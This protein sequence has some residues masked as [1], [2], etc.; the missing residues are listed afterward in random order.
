[1][2]IPDF[3]ILGHSQAVRQRFWIPPSKVRSSAPANYM[4]D[5]SFNFIK[6]SNETYSFSQNKE[7]KFVFTKLQEGIPKDKVAAR[8]VGGCVRK[9]L[10]NDEV[11]DIDIATILSSDEIKEK[12][13]N[14][15]FKIIDTL[16]MGLLL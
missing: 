10:S 14:T 7:L 8:F 1:M 5:L 15:N 16:N 11:D 13:D 2:S 3:L 12:F 9:H 4:F 6:K